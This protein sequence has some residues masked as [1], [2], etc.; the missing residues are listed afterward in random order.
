M[1]SCSPRIL[2]E[3]LIFDF[4]N[5]TFMLAEVS[6]KFFFRSVSLLTT[7]ENWLQCVDTCNLSERF[8]SYGR[9]SKEYDEDRHQRDDP[10]LSESSTQLG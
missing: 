7:Q 4:L 3:N 8:G 6:S 1:R 5:E 9:I 2:A 10:H